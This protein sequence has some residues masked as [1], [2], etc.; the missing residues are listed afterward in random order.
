MPYQNKISYLIQ[1]FRH[2]I[3]HFHYNLIMMKL[4]NTFCDP[5][6]IIHFSNICVLVKNL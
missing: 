4:L 3:T 6:S 2:F 5:K 1:K